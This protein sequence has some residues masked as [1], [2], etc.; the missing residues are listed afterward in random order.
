MHQPPPGPIARLRSLRYVELNTPAFTETA[1][2]YE[3]VW[4]PE[5]VESDTGARW[6]RGTGDEHHVLHLAE[7]ERVGLGRLSFAV[8]TPA[9][10]DEAARRLDARGI[11][12]VF[13]PGPLQQAGGG[14][15]LRFTDPEGRL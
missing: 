10:V 14:Y 2:F 8:T 15:G 3:E 11:V 6:L 5:T 4:G 9:E 12:P 7:R 13:G 1:D